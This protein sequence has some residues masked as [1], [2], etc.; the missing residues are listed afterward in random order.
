[1]GNKSHKNMG[2]EPLRSKQPASRL[3]E[4]YLERLRKD[5]MEHLRRK[6]DTSEVTIEVNNV[7]PA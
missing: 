4:R 6:I 1:M 7:R 3:A 2:P 5:R